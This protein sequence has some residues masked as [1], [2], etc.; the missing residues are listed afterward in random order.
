MA[1]GG[2][3]PYLRQ[4]PSGFYWEPS[5][6]IRRLGYSSEPL[7]KDVT[8][9]VKRAVT[10]N[11]KVMAA[12]ADLPPLAP[13]SIEGTVGWIIERYKASNSWKR[14]APKTQ[15]NYQKALS[16]ISDWWATELVEEITRRDIKAC[17]E[18]LEKN[19]PSMAATILKVF[20]VVMHHARDMG[21]K[22][23]NFDKLKLHTG[24]GDGEPWADYEISA[25]IDEAIRRGRA[26]MALAAMMAVSIGQREADV[27]DMRRT[28]WDQDAEY[29]TAGGSVIRGELTFRQKKTGKDLTVPV[30]PELRRA[31]GAAPMNGDRFVV[32]E[33]SGE[34][35]GEDNFRRVH[36]QICRAAGISDRR[37]FMHLRHT[38]AT[39]LGEAGCTEDEIR[40]ITGHTS[41]EIKKY[42]RPNA[43]MARA[44]IAKFD[45]HRRRTKGE[46]RRKTTME[47]DGK[48]AEFRRK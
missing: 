48:V 18:E 34:K 38:G 22:I 46:P 29:E 4:T 44:A 28:A 16:R 20:R 43:T 23:D 3:I 47:T 17:Q 25:Y 35:Y 14:L 2:L 13:S 19:A 7:G 39:R 45:D 6:R 30:L 9:A 8:A 1:K 27:I 12:I 41:A 40:A 5:R 26:S 10:L 11:A 36:R 42:V 24:G 31:L 32:S 21:Y 33:F 15:S 37:K